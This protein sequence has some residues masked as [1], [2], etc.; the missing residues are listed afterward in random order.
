MKQSG[1]ANK[2]LAILI[3][4]FKSEFRTRYAVNAIVMFALVT[5]VAVGFSTGGIALHK[6]MQGILLWLVIYFA[7]IAGLGQSFI[8]EEE[9]RTATALRLY[10]SASSI[11][12][13]KFLFNLLLLIGLV[14][15]IVPI[16]AVLIGLEIKCY[17]L[18][19]A[20]L[21]L[22]AISLAGST[23]LIAAIISKA[24]IKGVLMAALSFPVILPLLIIAIKGT[25]KSLYDN[26]IFFD[27]LPE[28]KVLLSYAVVMTVVGFLLFDYVWND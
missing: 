4:D 17:S 18:F 16:F 22:A 6:D 1:L 14:I 19:L 24:S 26:A 11:Y 13:G 12:C 5:V 15:V 7:S 27:G 2:A 25:Q 8:K 3:K 23:T 9:N 10:A 28:L 20:V 21:I